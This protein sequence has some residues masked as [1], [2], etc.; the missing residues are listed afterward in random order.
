MNGEG[1]DATWDG[2]KTHPQESAADDVELRADVVSQRFGITPR[3]LRY[4][5]ALGAVKPRRIGSVR[6]YSRADCD[7]IALI[8]KDRRLAGTVY[9]IGRLLERDSSPAACA[10]G[11]VKCAAQIRALQRTQT[12]IGLALTELRRIDSLLATKMTELATKM[13]ERSQ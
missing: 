3:A 8:A 4:Y 11:R 13:T 6:V 12:E 5:E 2:R 7:R 10:L 9:E 1:T